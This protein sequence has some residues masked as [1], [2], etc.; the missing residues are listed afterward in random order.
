[1]KSN[2]M[3]LQAYCV[4]GANVKDKYESMAECLVKFDMSLDEIEDEDLLINVITYRAI[5]SFLENPNKVLSG[6]ERK[7]R[8]IIWN[9]LEHNEAITRKTAIAWTRL[10]LI[11][12]RLDEIFSDAVHYTTNMTFQN[13][14]DGVL[15]HSKM[16]LLLITKTKSILVTITPHLVMY[17]GMSV[18]SN[19]DTNMCI[20][21]LYEADMAPNEIIDLSYDPKT[22]SRYF[23]EKKINLSSFDFINSLEILDREMSDNEIDLT[24]CRVCPGRRGCFP[25]MLKE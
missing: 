6:I 2:D 21:Y 16:D 20:A 8:E 22:V 10:S 17:P 4:Y 5:E 1:M 18:I 11:I 19:I 25:N 15:Y 7:F 23:Y 13:T 14:Y 3:A 9:R 24:K 12:K